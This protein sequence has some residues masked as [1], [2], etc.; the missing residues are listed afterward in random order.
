VE[1]RRLS[2]LLTGRLVGVSTA[3]PTRRGQ[4]TP[5]NCCT[6]A[7]VRSRPRNAALFYD[8]VVT[9]RVPPPWSTRGRTGRRQ[10]CHV[11]VVA[12]VNDGEAA[13]TRA[14]STSAVAADT[15]CLLRRCQRVCCRR[16]CPC[17]GP[18]C[19]CVFHLLLVGDARVKLYSL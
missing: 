5:V 11:A 13:S 8:A 19:V 4:L 14:E 7:V 10:P 9:S 2:E 18:I 16:L 6:D 12:A 3:E 17:C 1:S 15:G